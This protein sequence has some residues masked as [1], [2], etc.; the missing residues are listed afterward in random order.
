MLG[1]LSPVAL[2]LKAGGGAGDGD[3]DGEIALT[4]LLSQGGDQV[5]TQAR[6]DLDSFLDQYASNSMAAA[7]A[8]TPSAIRGAFEGGPVKLTRIQ[9]CRCFA[10]LLALH[11][12]G[13][14]RM[15]QAGPYRELEIMI[16][17]TGVERC[18]RDRFAA[19]LIT[20]VQSQA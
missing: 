13:F 18:S 19:A 12:R 5:L 11:G 1:T 15:E 8:T 3:D 17:T 10:E 14:I 7:A 6:L 9:A 20:Q 2:S 16:T 4:A